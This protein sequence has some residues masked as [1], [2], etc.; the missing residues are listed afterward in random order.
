MTPTN[1]PVI[2]EMDTVSKQ[3]YLVYRKPNMINP[4][5][6]IL[7]VDT[8]NQAGYFIEFASFQLLG[9]NQKW[10]KPS[11]KLELL[12]QS[13]GIIYSAHYYQPDYE[14]VVDKDTQQYKFYALSTA[15]IPLVALNYAYV[16]RIVND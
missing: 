5:G 2:Y 7:R 8:S 11:F 14:M 13:G 1:L 16:I 6:Q 15:K 3:S 12:D 4:G 10:F 9:L